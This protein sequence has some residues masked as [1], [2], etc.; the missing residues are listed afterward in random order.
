VVRAALISA[1]LPLCVFAEPTAAELARAVVAAVPDAS[2]CYRVRDLAFSEEDIRFYLTDGY[3]VFSKPV[4]GRPVSAIFSSDLDGGDAEVIVLP[5]HRGDRQSLASFI[6]SANL[7]EH[8]RSA[9]F[10]LTKSVSEQLHAGVRTYGRKAPEAGARLAGQWSDVQRDLSESMERRIVFD[11]LNPGP[12]NAL[13]FAVLGGTPV[14]NFDLFY[15]P[16]A[17]QQIVVGQLSV[18][19]DPP[20][21]D[22]WT[23]FE[24]RSVRL[25]RKPRPESRFTMGD[26]RINA[27]LD[28]K[29]HVT[30]TTRAKITVRDPGMR[31]ILFQISP[32]M[33]ITR[34]SIDGRP[35]EVFAPESLRADAVHGKG[36]SA[37]LLV[38]P[39]PLAPG[40][41][42]E[43]EI[44]HD[45]DV[46]QPAGNGVFYVESR[47][48]W[49]PR[50]GTA[51]ARYDLTFRYPKNLTLLA[52]GEVAG[53]R[54]DG[55]FRVTHYTSSEPIRFAGFNLGNYRHVDLQEGPYDIVVYANQR[56]EPSL[57]RK[58]EVI[59]RP[60]YPN[61]L[62]RSPEIVGVAAPPPDPVGALSNLAAD[63]GG[64]M[65]FYT[66]L[67]GPL[68]L[69]TLTVSPIPGNFGQGFPGLVYLST[70]AYLRPDQRPIETRSGISG[71]FYSDILV[72][73]EVAHQWWGNLVATASA[74]DDWLMEALANYSAMLY[75]EKRKGP[76]AL[77]LV[78][79]RFRA[80]LLAKSESGAT[81]ES[82]GP[83]VWGLR[84]V[85]S[86][87]RSA[88]QII[89][90]EKGA[91]ILHMLRR[92]M[93]DA[94]FSAMLRELCRRYAYKTVTTEEFRALAEE[95]MPKGHPGSLDPFFETWVYGTGIP[96][97]RLSYTVRGR[98]RELRIV[99]T[100][101]QSDVDDDFSCLAPIE[102]DEANRPP[103]IHWVETSSD[104]VNFSI[105]VHERPIKV[106]V[107]EDSVLAARR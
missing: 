14:G 21:F 99:G 51:F 89:T 9:F 73:H 83:V 2:E 96:S 100:L 79:D 67:F 105:P 46:V 104:P 49:Y 61:P 90:Y 69:K 23:A 16:T 74:Q 13:F 82:A 44:E 55:D 8:F 75:L 30:C 62:R 29:L 1:L 98:G 91:W 19:Y 68:R 60:A 11:L 32:Y 80:D 66:S 86:H 64:A 63:V 4:Q 25:G 103:V 92:R 15:D 101:R 12:E 72:P 56:V 40:V 95:F 42:H 26:V 93:G 5:P 24:A 33:H 102:I 43:V 36:L 37:F 28:E 87:S 38:A 6:H 34:G 57:E 48:L 54:I 97:L 17:P 84:L 41:P 58:G 65:Q 39:Q 31:A 27:S 35:A 50:I 47:A 71:N 88:W 85:T 3:L 107:G 59:I 78:L 70:L 53:D 81:V 20:T 106:V 18:K 45:G 22:I 7:D 94:Q 10:L 77:D 76:K 52:T